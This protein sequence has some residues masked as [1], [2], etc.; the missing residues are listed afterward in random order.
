MVLAAPG[1]SCTTACAV[2]GA[3]SRCLPK[4]R[5]TLPL[6]RI[7]IAATVAALGLRCSSFGTPHNWPAYPL[8]HHRGGGPVLCEPSLPGYRRF[9]CGFASTQPNAQRI[10]PCSQ[11]NTNL[12]PVLPPPAPVGPQGGWQSAPPTPPP[13]HDGMLTGLRTVVV[14]PPP[15]SC[16][17]PTTQRG[18]SSADD[19]VCNPI[20]TA[21]D[22]APSHLRVVIS[23]GTY[24]NRGYASGKKDNPTLV[25]VVNKQFLELVAAPGGAMPKLLFDGDGAIKIIGS[26]H[27]RVSGL[28]IQG[29][30]ARISGADASR[31]R[32]RMTS[33]SAGGGRTGLCG[34]MECS[35][36]LQRGRCTA[37]SYCRWKQ[38]GFCE[39]KPLSY[40]N[41]P[42]VR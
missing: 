6:A 7:G 40:F 21:V 17:S 22:S 33:R 42:G 8:L 18:S 3:G 34:P 9:N 30:A 35:S 10:C 20:Q 39:P 23:A 14:H 31:N 26:S 24:T 2:R 27:V 37:T 29:P 4:I 5:D 32:L 41:A 12:P 15:A 36:C 16:T 1:Q 25:K 19:S 38:N 11:S 13:P 28:E